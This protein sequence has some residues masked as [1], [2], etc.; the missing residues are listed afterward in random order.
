MSRVP[1]SLIR[2]VLHDS[3][4]FRDRIFQLLR[5]SVLDRGWS[6]GS[7]SLFPPH[8]ES[9]RRSSYYSYDRSTNRYDRIVGLRILGGRR[10]DWGSSHVYPTVHRCNRGVNGALVGIE[11]RLVE[12][13]AEA[14]S[15]VE[16]STAQ[17]GCSP[18]GLVR[19]RV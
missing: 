14:L 1:R 8:K 19:S 9:Q 15:R 18:L 2:R 12:S 16:T 4:P 17:Q 7:P 11:T 6:N 5:L 13:V 10:C 3:L